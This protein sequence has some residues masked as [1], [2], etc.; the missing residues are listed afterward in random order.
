VGVPFYLQQAREETVEEIIHKPTLTV[1]EICEILPFS[2]YVVRQAARRGE[3]RA[4]MF[5]HHIYGVRRQDLV[6][7]L[8]TRLAEKYR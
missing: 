7:W 6:A 4:I 8:R 5:D 3:L 1:E 2:P